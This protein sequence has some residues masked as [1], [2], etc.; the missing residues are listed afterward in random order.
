MIAMSDKAALKL[1]Y[2]P[3]NIG[4]KVINIWLHPFVTQSIDT[5]DIIEAII[6]ASI[7]LKI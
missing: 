1:S 6:E 5:L 3:A 7:D 4:Y 2:T